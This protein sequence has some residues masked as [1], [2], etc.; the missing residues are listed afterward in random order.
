[1]IVTMRWKVFLLEIA[2]CV[3]K[4]SEKYNSVT[5]CLLT[6]ILLILLVLLISDGYCYNVAVFA[7]NL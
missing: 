7:T 2:L 4:K 3:N 5:V 1:M 6:K